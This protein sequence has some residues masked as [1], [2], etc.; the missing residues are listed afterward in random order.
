MGAPD[1]AYDTDTYTGG[2]A[3]RWLRTHAQDLNDQG[4]PWFLVVSFV[5]PHDIMYADANQLGKPVQVSQVGMTLTPPPDNDHFAK[6]W[7]FHALTSHIDLVPTLVGLSNA[8]PQL[9][10]LVVKGLQGRNFTPLLDAPEDAAAD[11]VREAV[12]FNYVG[13]QTVDA[14][15]MM[16]VCRDIAEGPFRAAL[17]GGEAG[18]HAARFISFVFDGRYKFARYYAPDNFNIPETLDELLANN[19][20][21]LFDLESDPD[22]LNN[23]GADPQAHEDLIMRMNAMLTRMIARKVGV[24]DG[25]FL[26]QALRET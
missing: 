23:L 5:S 17:H 18:S 25:K 1:Q 22:E 3:I 26:P 16:R 2:A 20:I 13:L 8:D 12:L 7:R 9:Q 21:E 15:Y 11:A 24:N 4:K 14:L 10:E 6:Q 19:E